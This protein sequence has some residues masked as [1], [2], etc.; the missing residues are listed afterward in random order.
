MLDTA[1]NLAFFL[2]C[3]I[4]LVNLFIRSIRYCSPRRIM[5]SG[6]K[7][8]KRFRSVASN[9][10]LSLCILFTTADISDVCIA[11]FRERHRS[12]ATPHTKLVTCLAH[13]SPVL[14]FRLVIASLSLVRSMYFCWSRDVDWYNECDHNLHHSLVGTVQVRVMFGRV[15]ISYR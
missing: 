1:F 8:K 7:R 11:L 12:C 6:S 15:A 3:S 5:A 9:L 14:Y 13:V 4:D 2:L 10:F